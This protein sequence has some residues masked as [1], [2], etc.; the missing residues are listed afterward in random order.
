MIFERLKTVFSGL[1]QEV[2]KMKAT[3]ISKFLLL[4]AIPA[5]S[6]VFTVTNTDD[7][8]DNSLRWAL[9]QAN[10]QA[11]PD[12]VLFNI[13]DTSPG[14]GDKV[15]TITLQFALPVF[16]DAATFVNAASQRNTNPNGPE[17]ILDGHQTFGAV[18]GLVISSAK[19]IIKNLG[20]VSFSDN[21][22]LITGPGARDNVITG[23]YIGV[24]PDGVAARANSGH[25][26]YVKSAGVKNRIGGNKADQR[27]LISGNLK[28]G[29]QIEKADSTVVQGNYIGCDA[30]AKNKLGNQQSGIFLYGSAQ[31]T[32]IGGDAAEEGNVISGNLWHGILMQGNLVKQ[33]LISHNRIG[34]DLA[35]T[36][37]LGNERY[38]LY[39][40]GGASDNTIGPFNSILNNKKYGICISSN[41]TLRNHITQNAISKNFNSA[42]QLTSGGN[43]GV[44][45]PTG[46]I[47]A[48]DGVKGKAPARSV[49]EIYSDPADEGAWFEA[50][51][52]TD[53]LGNF[54]WAGNPKGPSV[55]ATMTDDLG[56]TSEFTLPLRIVPFTVTTTRD[57]L[58]GSLRWA[59]DGSNLTP[60]ADKILFDIPKT[61]PGFQAAKGVWVIKPTKPLPWL[62]GGRVELDGSSQ[63]KKQG[64]AN[65]FG[66]EI[67]LDGSLAGDKAKGLEIR[68][69]H[70]WVHDLGIG[71]FSQNAIVLIGEAGRHNRITGCYVGLDATGKG[72]MPLNGWSGIV[73]ATADS[74]VIGGNEPGLRNYIVAMG[75]HGILLSG[76]PCRANALIN[77][78]VGLDITGTKALPNLKDGIRLEK[79]PAGNIIG[80]SSAQERN[81]CSGN[82]RTGI[83]LEGAGVDS[84]IVVG[85]WVG[86]VASGTDSL[87]NGE[88]GILLADHARYNIIGGKS[89]ASGNVISGNHFSGIQIRGNSD[90]NMIAYN[91]IGLDAARTKALGNSQHGIFVFSAAANNEIGPANVIAGNGRSGADAGSGVVLDGTATKGNK[92]FNNLIGW[93]SETKLGNTGHGV[94]LLNGC[95]ENRIGPENTIAQNGGDGV[96]VAGERTVFNTISKNSIF[97]NTGMGIDNQLGGNLD[98]APPN[99]ALKNIGT[100]FGTA[101]PF[102]KVEVFTGLDEEGQR[103]LG[104]VVAD[105]KGSFSMAIGRTDSVLSATATDVLGNTSEFS[106]N[107][108]TGVLD[109]STTV[110]PIVF[111]LQQNYPNP[112]N[113]GTLIS[114]SLPTPQKVSI[115]LYN[116]HGQKVAKLLE[117]SLQAGSHSITW[118]ARDDQGHALPSGVYVYV[119]NAGALQSWK[120]LILLR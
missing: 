119:L 38:G 58:E 48:A 92:L 70:N 15:W 59:I 43:A 100:V 113:A 5:F 86:L 49:V 8:G 36:L 80:G 9:M 66:P 18:N 65:L 47:V 117:Q 56:N 107:N 17:I 16:A 114:F 4:W 25:G 40:Y 41:T 54:Y 6:A 95:M 60:E 101:Q 71:S 31:C 104:T 13:P 7:S 19:N 51:V 78:Y 116:V 11:G 75:L 30:G 37:D 45:P 24:S 81:V 110:M 85:N 33:C 61:D 1:N 118:T 42:I 74:N 89:P 14:Y 62:T 10:I 50:A 93:D 28:N 23:C 109:N 46:L 98:L 63:S 87:A 97:N 105:A 77:N 29:I 32:L 55:T 99:F 103:Y 120:K 94:Y 3:R 102:A 84:N 22:I 2:T 44:L 79:G 88:S 12:T 115:V 26:I 57:S 34:T 111:T 90:Y 27:N 20:I 39:L 108:P 68:S 53:D 106:R 67:F 96:R 72:A 69:A 35:T 76:V 83:R 91:T 64:D 73:I 112:F 82:G 52:I 21:G